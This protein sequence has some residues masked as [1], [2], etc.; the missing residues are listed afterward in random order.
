MSTT[1]R[2]WNTGANRNKDED[3]YDYEGFIN[4][5]V[6]EAYGK[7]MHKHRHLADGTMRDSDNWQNL[8]G[9]EHIKVCT[10]SLIRH[11][12]D[13]WMEN[14]G[15]DSRDGIDEALGG[16]IFNA[17]AIWFKILKDRRDGK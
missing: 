14:R 15:Y 6:F 2:T 3:K 16:I 9:D 1:N 12:H 7:Y 5:L 8:F 11:T 4:P 13:V 10:K 17:M